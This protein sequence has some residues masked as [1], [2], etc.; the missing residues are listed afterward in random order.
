MKIRD[1][2]KTVRMNDGYRTL[3]ESILVPEVIVAIKDWIKASSSTNMVLIGGLA[4]SYY[5]KPRATQDAGFLF[6]QS[7]DI[8]ELVN[9]FKRNRKSAFQHNKTHV[10]IELVTP[11]LIGIDKSIALMVFQTA[12]E[13]DGIK[14]ANP[15]GLVS[16][17]LFRFNLQDQ[18][19]IVELIKTGK[20]DLK[21]WPLPKDKVHQFEE[22]RNKWV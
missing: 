7:A 19:D 22:L 17:K 1:L 6:L 8:P 9:G 18:A 10:E 14:V 16:L 15:S 3:F 5:V 20:V 2:I 12:I 4:L 13:Q 21:G 11:E